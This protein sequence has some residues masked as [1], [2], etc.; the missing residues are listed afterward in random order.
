MLVKPSDPTGFKREF[1]RQAFR[2]QNAG[3]LE[4]AYAAA[5]RYAPMVQ[6]LIPGGDDAST[7][8]GAT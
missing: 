3:E 7:R 4:R 1:G 2:C 5:E 8:S 6:E